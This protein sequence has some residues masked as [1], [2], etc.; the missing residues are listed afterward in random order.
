MKLVNHYFPS[1]HYLP[2]YFKAWCG[3]M[4]LNQGP[5][6]V[7][8]H[9]LCQEGIHFANLKCNKVLRLES[10]GSKANN[11]H[12][13]INVDRTSFGYIKPNPAMFL[14]AQQYFQLILTLEWCFPFNH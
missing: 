4:T 1:F 3:H 13:H 2:P 7:G 8:I 10:L 12:L 9:L 5:I 6:E 11:I 14:Q